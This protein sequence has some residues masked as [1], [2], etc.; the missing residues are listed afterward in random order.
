[1]NN[2][3]MYQEPQQL[4]QLPPGRNPQHRVR[5]HHTRPWLEPPGVVVDEVVEP[6]PAIESPTTV[7]AT[8]WTLSV[9]FSRRSR[10]A[11]L[12]FSHARSRASPIVRSSISVRGAER[13]M[14]TPTASAR[15]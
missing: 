12:A 3:D 6:A 7:S 10:A 9:T 8:D 5:Q 2:P 13:P 14:A 15:V 11:W 4:A 1:M